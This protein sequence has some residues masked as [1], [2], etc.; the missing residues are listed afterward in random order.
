MND[1]V[2]ALNELANEESMT[3][4]MVGGTGHDVTDDGYVANPDSNKDFVVGLSLAISSSLFIGASFIFKKKGLLRLEAKGQARA[5]S[6]GHAYL[7]EPIWWAGIIS[8]ALGEIANFVAYAY[9]PATLV[10]PLGA[11]SVLVTAVLSARFL[12][13]RLNLHG[14][15]GCL[16]AI[17]GSTVMVIHAPKEENVNGLVELGTMMMMPGFLAYTCIAL[18]VSLFLIF[19]IAPA[20]GQS[21]VL[22]YIIICSLLGSFSVACVK[23]V[24]LVIKQFFNPNDENPFEDAL[25]YFLILCLAMSVTTQINYLNKSLDI[26]NTSIVTPIYYVMFTTAVLTC[27]GVLYQEWRGMTPVDVIGTIAGFGTIII[28]IFLL[29]AF[30][31]TEDSAKFD[32]HRPKDGETGQAE[33]Q[34]LIDEE[35]NEPMINA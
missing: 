4:K 7:F 2:P 30:R 34:V 9:A 29:H 15:M 10:T 26:F 31:G 23:G 5:G 21:N 33:Y 14:K 8:M 18:S 25:T 13:E 3:P 24:G 19:K 35:Q 20:H 16:L 17:L 11:L 22:V 1:H 32:L 27:S 28:G 6:G 12:Q